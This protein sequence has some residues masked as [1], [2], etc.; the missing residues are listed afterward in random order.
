M[1]IVYGMYC[2]WTVGTTKGKKILENQK[3]AAQ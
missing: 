3:A 1:K 2:T